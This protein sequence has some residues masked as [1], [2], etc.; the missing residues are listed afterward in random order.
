MAGIYIHIPF[1]KQACH[2][3]NF[4]FSTSLKYKSQM[5]NAIMAEIDIQRDYLKGE[6]IETIYFGGGTPS[7]LSKE[8]LDLFFEKIY[9]VHT[10]SENP[11][12]TFEANPDDLTLEKLR[13]LKQTRINRLSIGIQ[14]FS[15]EDLQYMNRAHNAKEAENCIRFA[16]DLGFENLTIDLI[17]GSPTTSDLQWETNLQT[18]FDHQ[19]PHISCYCLTIEPKTALAHFVKVGKAKPVDE[20]QSAR[21]FEML[22]HAMKRN[23]Y[24]HYEISNFAKEGWYSKHNSNYWKGAKYLGL[25]PSAHSFDGESRQW[26]IANNAQYLKAI[27]NGFSSFEKE[28]ISPETRYNEYV[29]TSL[30]TSWGCDLNELKKI[31]GEFEKFFL[32]NVIPFITNELV[33][34]KR[35]RIYILTEKGKLLADNIAM[36]LFW[37]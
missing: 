34:E 25:G 37:E 12:I 28:I 31:G 20:H 11:E 22:I 14:S 2:Y 29:M 36:E 27:Q 35:N 5:V 6:Q 23:E 9:A 15:E 8:D 32:K 19:I 3:C 1:C 4:H 17:Y 7:L 10:V 24:E 33:E 13:E 26:N 16:Q 30:R 21:Q 18:V